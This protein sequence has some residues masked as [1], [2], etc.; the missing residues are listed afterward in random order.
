VDE[1]DSVIVVAAGGS[2]LEDDILRRYGA[3]YRVV[4]PSD[5]DAAHAELVDLAAA[6]DDVA[7]ILC[8][9][10]SDPERA[11]AMLRQARTLHPVARRCAVVRWGDFASARW[12]FDALATGGIDRYLI[13][14]DHRN[15]EE[16][17]AGITDAL[18][19]W[20]VARGRGFEAVVLVGDARSARVQE[21]RDAFHRN[22]IP[23]GF[24][25]A[26]STT[27]AELLA[28]LG[29]PEGPFPVLALRFTPEHAV[30]TDPADAEI[31]DAFGLMTPL[32]ADEHFDVTIV[33]AGPSGLAAA[34]Y[35]AS[36]GLKTLV[37]EQEAVGGQAGTSSLIRNYPGF[38][39]GVSG[40]KLAFNAFRQAWSF[41]ARFHFMR[42]VVGLRVDGADRVVSLS[43]GTEV[44]STT[45][46][47]AA[48]V[49]YRRLG[50]APLE[51]L[52][53]RGV[54]YGAAVTQA[55]ATLGGHAVVLGG[56]NSAGQA[57]VHLARYAAR[58]TV[59][60]RRPTLAETMSEYLVHEIES[61][62]NIDVR[63]GAEVVGGG[64]DPVL[65]HLVLRSTVDG[66][67]ERVGADALF[68]LIGSEPRTGWLAGVV[69]CDAWGFPL[70]GEE[71]ADGGDRLPGPLETDVPGVFAVGDVRRGSV[72]RVASA[73][74]E[75][76]MVVPYVHRYVQE[77]QHVG[78]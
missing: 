24:H 46:V 65:D 73:V 58:V 17:H 39:W 3:D 34:V 32:P 72:K 21:L 66:S 37:I 44:R 59:V 7:L 30:L 57:A 78:S 11:V 13:R 4:T 28:S 74:G 56:G 75:G 45:V 43:D 40:S 6:G 51:E 10:S 41:G 61:T 50:V 52:V 62:D 16:L 64:G 77:R 2:A 23:T 26:T 14:P 36:E 12:V 70:T 54:F 18:A 60:V 55:P 47:I 42:S 33:G 71:A 5:L 76:A 69:G 48:G 29:V 38:S 49:T 35:A 8:D 9:C 1:R 68:V 19:D 20:Q 53:G 15:D 67:E 25:D 31:A 63:Y 27:G 22:H